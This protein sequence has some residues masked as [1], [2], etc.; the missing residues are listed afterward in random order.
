MG[1]FGHMPFF[2]ILR[3]FKARFVEDDKF[4]LLTRFTPIWPLHGQFW[5]ILDEVSHKQLKFESPKTDLRPGSSA[6]AAPG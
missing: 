1:K 3:P 6:V 4:D 2:S 5:P